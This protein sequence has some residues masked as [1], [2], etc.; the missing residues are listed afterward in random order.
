MEWLIALYTAE[1][2]GFLLHS[3]FLIEC[4]LPNKPQ[5]NLTKAVYL[6]KPHPYFQLS[7]LVA[8]YILHSVA[9]YYIYLDLH[10]DPAFSLSGLFSSI[11]MGPYAHIMWRL[12]FLSALLYVIGFIHQYGHLKGMTSGDGR[13]VFFERLYI[14][15]QFSLVNF[16][17]DIPGWFVA[18]TI[19][20]RTIVQVINII[21]LPIFLFI[22]F[23]YERF[24]LCMGC[25]N[26]AW[27][28]MDFNY[29][30]CDGCYNNPNVA[31]QPVC[32]QEGVHCGDASML[33]KRLLNRESYIVEI[34]LMVSVG[35]YLS[36]IP[37]KTDHY[38]DKQQ[39]LV[40]VRN[41]KE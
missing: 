18:D 4:L 35:I 40:Q 37:L 1:V 38:N 11:C 20:P 41:S 31:L 16:S 3:P 28:F 14:L 25:F 36:N 29:G 22:Y 10:H 13:F 9:I 27:T 26:P 33:N 39:M 8:R 7:I 34:I 5:K 19:V 23:N 17:V 24:V 15:S 12:F 2:W 6:H 21:V 32:D 30:F